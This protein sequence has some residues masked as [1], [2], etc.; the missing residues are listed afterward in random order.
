MSQPYDEIIAGI[1]LR[2]GTEY[3]DRPEDRGGPTKFGITIKTLARYRGLTATV[4]DVQELEVQEARA[5]YEKLYIRDPEFDQILG[6]NQP[7]GLEVIDTGVNCGVVTAGI[8]LQRV[9]NAFNMKGQHYHNLKLD[10]VCGMKTRRALMIFLARRKREGETI[11]LRALNALQGERYISIAERD[12]EQ[13]AN[14]YGWFRTR[15]VL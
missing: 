13:E 3:S 10:G 15:V 6:L 11:M 2:E 4:Q 8:M 9:L 14:V 1:I 5:I 7:I 12:E